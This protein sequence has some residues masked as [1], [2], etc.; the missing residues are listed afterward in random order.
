[1]NDDRDPRFMPGPTSEESRELW[2]ARHFA[3]LMAIVVAAAVALAVAAARSC[4]SSP[5]TID[6]GL[7][8]AD[9]Q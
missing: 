6:A 2:I 3:A 1:M 7:Y 8:D 5:D 9:G 4:S